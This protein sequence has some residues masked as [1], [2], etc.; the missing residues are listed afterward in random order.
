MAPQYQN[1]VQQREGHGEWLHFGEQFPSGPLEP[2]VGTILNV[3]RGYAGTP[4]TWEQGWAT[5]A[6]EAGQRR[7]QHTHRPKNKTGIEDCLGWAGS[8]MEQNLSG[9]KCQEQLHT[10]TMKKW[11]LSFLRSTPRLG[12]SSRGRKCNR[13]GSALLD[14]CLKNHLFFP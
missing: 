1:W 9:V 4:Q 8:S 3:S 11:R 6:W 7:D 13:G 5:E 12:R 14:L 10:G 2:L